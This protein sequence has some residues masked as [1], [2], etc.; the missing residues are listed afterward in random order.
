LVLEN[1][2][3]GKLKKSRFPKGDKEKDVKDSELQRKYSKIIAEKK[4]KIASTM[5]ELPQPP[6]KKRR[7]VIN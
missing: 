6:R 3:V 7:L 2:N 4:T 1:S 5:K